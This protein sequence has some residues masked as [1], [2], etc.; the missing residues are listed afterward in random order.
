MFKWYFMQFLD[1]LHL[2]FV[3]VES[4]VVHYYREQGLFASLMV[5]DRHC[6]VF[7]QCRQCQ[8]SLCSG[9]HQYQRLLLTEKNIHVEKNII[10]KV[11]K[12]R[13][14]TVNNLSHETLHPSGVSGVYHFHVL[15]GVAQVLVNVTHVAQLVTTESPMIMCCFR[16]RLK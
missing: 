7:A 11:T 3:L 16:F 1:L 4:T 13:N 5:R 8:Y 15:A 14:V 10:C 9:C 2:V 12:H 6:A